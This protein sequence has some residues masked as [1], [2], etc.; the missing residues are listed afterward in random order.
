VG[1]AQS[2]QNSYDLGYSKNQT[3]IND[4]KPRLKMYTHPD[5]GN[6]RLR[7]TRIGRQDWYSLT[8]LSG[9]LQ[10]TPDEITRR[11]SHEWQMTLDTG[12]T[13]V[14]DLAIS[15][16]FR[17]EY[18][19]NALLIWIRDVIK[20]D[21]FADF[22][23][24][25]HPWEDPRDEIVSD[26]ALSAKQLHKIF[27]RG[28]RY[29]P[30]VSRKSRIGGQ[31]S[32]HLRFY[33][34]PKEDDSGHFDVYRD[35]YNVSLELAL[36]IALDDCSFGGRLARIVI[37]EA[38]AGEH[39]QESLDAAIELCTG[40]IPD[41]KNQIDAR[42][43]HK[44]LGVKT[45]FDPWI[46]KPMK[47]FWMLAG[48]DYLTATEGALPGKSRPRS[49]PKSTEVISISIQSAK[50][51]SMLDPSRRG[52]HMGRYHLRCGESPSPEIGPPWR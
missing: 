7:A 43:F 25:D 34:E 2:G 27:G 19:G 32:S 6:L 35:D 38:I 3:P 30:W 23:P 45:P 16:L 22:I 44:F 49:G 14:T 48:R 37:L 42:L 21:L 8:D 17:L 18:E 33:V 28:V 47:D 50:Y 31:D 24:E 11:Y 9:I 52:Y 15:L 39:T 36:R 26:I 29:Y 10:T 13:L 1:T 41:D 51:I 5:F 20:K 40:L 4:M 12:E 46:A